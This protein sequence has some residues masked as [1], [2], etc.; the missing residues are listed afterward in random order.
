MSIKGFGSS[1]DEAK[2]QL[3]QKK[4]APERNIFPK[5]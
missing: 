5:I 1:A 4:D 3:T 2:S